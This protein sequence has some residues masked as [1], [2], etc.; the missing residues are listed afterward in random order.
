MSA[1]I[2][3][4]DPDRSCHTTPR[5]ITA[6][7]RADRAMDRVSSGCVYRAEVSRSATDDAFTGSSDLGVSWAC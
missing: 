1:T 6:G 2:F 7:E 5:T 3:L 4:S